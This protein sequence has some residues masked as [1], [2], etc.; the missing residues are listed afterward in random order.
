MTYFKIVRNGGSVDVK[1]GNF[2]LGTLDLQETRDFNK[3]QVIRHL[4]EISPLSA[5]SLE[6][7]TDELIDAEIKKNLEKENCSIYLSV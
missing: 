5:G 4:N 3:S 1:R 6:E 7:A 2:E